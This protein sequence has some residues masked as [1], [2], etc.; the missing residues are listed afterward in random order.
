MK[1]AA[2][3]SRA[4]RRDGQFVDRW[5]IAGIAMLIVWAVAVLRFAAPGW[6]HGLLT[7]GVFLV[8]WRIVVKGTQ[9]VD[10]K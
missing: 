2:G 7:V 1:Q 9:A 5:L 8:I 6:M 4:R 3:Q 10:E